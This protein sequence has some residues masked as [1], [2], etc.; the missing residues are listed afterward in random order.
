[1][2]NIADGMVAGTEVVEGVTA[3]HSAV[4][5]RKSIPSSLLIVA[6]GNDEGSVEAEEG[7]PVNRNMSSSTLGSSA[8]SRSFLS[9]LSAASNLS[10]ASTS[11]LSSVQSSASG[12]ESLGPQGPP[13]PLAP[14]DTVGR[15]PLHYAATI[16]NTSAATDLLSAGA[17]QHILDIHGRSGKLDYSSIIQETSSLSCLTCC[18]D[19]ETGRQILSPRSEQRLKS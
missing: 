12:L 4:L 17:P 5:A 18:L 16:G 9:F 8:S 10:V 11:S 15:T 19:H 13:H 1:M 3:L 7:R 14:T 6:D 2:A